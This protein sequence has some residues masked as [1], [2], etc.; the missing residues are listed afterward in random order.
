MEN[1]RKTMKTKLKGQHNR[2]TSKQLRF[3]L[4]EGPLFPFQNKNEQG[5]AWYV[6]RVGMFERLDGIVP[7]RFGL[8]SNHNWTRVTRGGG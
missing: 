8:I 7:R 2:N 6:R 1:V 3:L 5:V 4:E